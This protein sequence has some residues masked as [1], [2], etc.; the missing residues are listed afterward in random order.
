MDRVDREI[1]MVEQQICKLRKKQVQVPYNHGLYCRSCSLQFVWCLSLFFITRLC[2]QLT[3]FQLDAIYMLYLLR[4]TQ[5]CLSV[6][7]LLIEPECFCESA[8]PAL[9]LLSACSLAV[10]AVFLKMFPSVFKSS[11]PLFACLQWIFTQ[12][13]LQTRHTRL[14]CCNYCIELL[15]LGLTQPATVLC[16]QAAAFSS[17]FPS[18]LLLLG[19]KQVKNI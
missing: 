4:M 5:M 9:F 6:S 16:F 8:W 1:T 14:Y 12:Q 7:L 13:S 18:S 17:A 3:V 11:I 15:Q 2:A 19:E 10:P